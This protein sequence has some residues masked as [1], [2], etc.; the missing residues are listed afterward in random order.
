MIMTECSLLLP[1]HFGCVE[2]TLGAAVTRSSIFRLMAR[3]FS[4]QT[5]FLTQREEKQQLSPVEDLSSAEK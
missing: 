3:F 2:G 5:F 1:N 4:F